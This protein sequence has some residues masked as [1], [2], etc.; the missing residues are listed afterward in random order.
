MSKVLSRYVEKRLLK[1]RRSGSG[2][3]AFAGKFK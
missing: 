1:A 3:R 2:G